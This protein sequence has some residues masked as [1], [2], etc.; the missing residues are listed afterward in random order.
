M[1]N[2]PLAAQAFAE[3]ARLI[4]AKTAGCIGELCT[5][6]CSLHDILSCRVHG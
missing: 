6:C 2:Q 5:H 4:V 3:K 1:D